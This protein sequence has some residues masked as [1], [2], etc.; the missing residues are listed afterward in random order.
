LQSKIYGDAILKEIKR[1]MDG[2]DY[3]L[4]SDVEKFEQ[5]LA[6]YVGTKYAVGV[7]SCTD[8]MRLIFRALNFKPHSEVIVSGHTFLAS[9][10][11][12]VDA[13]LKPVLI[14]TGADYNM[15]T[16]LIEKEI[17]KDTVAILP[18][19]L[20]GRCCNMD[21]IMQVA[22]KYKL[23]VIEDAA[24]ALGAEFRGKRAGSFGEGSC[25]NS[26][27]VIATDKGNKRIGLIQEGDYVLTHMNRYRKVTKVFKRWYKGEW[28]KIQVEGMRNCANWGSRYLSAT[29]EHPVLINRD[30]IRKWIPICDIKETDRVYIKR[31]KCRVCGRS[32][33]F[34]WTICEYC[35]PANMKGVGSKISKTKDTGKLPHRVTCKYSHYYE[36]IVPFANKLTN[37]GYRVIPIGV[38]VPDIIAIKDNKV[39]AY[40]I[41]RTRIYVKR[42]KNKYGELSK[43]YDDI[44]WVV[45]KPKHEFCKTRHKYFVED[46]GFIS[47][48]ITK[49]DKSEEIGRW[50][51]NLEVDE[52]NSYYASGVVVHNCFSFFPAKLLGT[53]GDAGAICTSDE[54]LAVKLKAMRD[55]GRVK[56]Q[57]QVVC[58][59]QNSRL[60]NVHAAI[61]NYKIKFIDQWI[62]RRREIA[63]IYC[64][65]LSG[66]NIGLPPLPYER[67][68]NFD[69]YQNFVIRVPN[70]D[71]LIKY[72]EENGVEVLVHW[73][74]PLNK[75]KAL[76]FK[77]KLPET[78][79]LCD[80]VI[81]LPMYQELTDEQVRYVCDT[82]N[83]WFK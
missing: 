67:D 24:Q 62:K 25:F 19:H 70:R 5:T 33:P 36:D 69:T 15:N 2:G 7:N 66:L 52:D 23:T 3:I 22:S 41:E 78:E 76:K 55:Y 38:A 73:R 59:G 63:T 1:V 50:V 47:M 30:G 42:K 20:N 60:D 68:I 74:T 32:V 53:I 77:C 14:D 26:K 40:E 21:K 18:V 44:I 58:Y 28:I 11:A 72:L 43:Y 46:D 83:K 6:E 82:I 57:E 71:D 48:N 51:Y 16:E 27:T 39:V 17:T 54:E 80:E 65:E 79:R 4:R 12:I 13:N 49:I 61:L 45:P 8:G 31:T 10:D 29:R 35:N 81:S 37:D 9:L 56:G 64:Q 34:H 75:Q